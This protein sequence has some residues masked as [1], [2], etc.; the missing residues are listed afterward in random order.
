MSETDTDEQGPART[1]EEVVAALELERDALHAQIV[2]ERREYWGRIEALTIKVRELQ[3]SIATARLDRGFD[4][5]NLD[6]K[7][8]V[9]L[10]SDAPVNTVDLVVDEVLYSFIDY[11]TKIGRTAFL[12]RAVEA[13]DARRHLRQLLSASSLAGEKKS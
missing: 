4:G 7:I 5:M 12:E 10:L 2:K 8:S 13:L 6:F 1:L 3:E 11:F 9:H